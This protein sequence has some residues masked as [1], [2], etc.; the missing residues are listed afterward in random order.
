[1]AVF[2]RQR[3]LRGQGPSTPLEGDRQTHSQALCTMREKQLR[4]F[5]QPGEEL[6]KIS[7]NFEVFELSIT[8]Q[9]GWITNVDHWTDCWTTWL[10]LKITFHNMA[11][12]QLWVF[13]IW[14]IPLNTRTTLNNS[15]SLCT[16]IEKQSQVFK[17]K[18][19]Q[20]WTTQHH[21]AEWLNYKSWSLNSLIK[22]LWTTWQIMITLHI[23]RNTTASLWIDGFSFS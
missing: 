7:S 5:E 23:G 13:K 6:W 14:R 19:E 3:Q 18:L 21:F 22:E 11:E 2:V 15:T 9:S 1:M 17:K 10:K 4:I 8:F 12:W 16:M 20:L